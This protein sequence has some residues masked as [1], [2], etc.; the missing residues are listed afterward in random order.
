MLRRSLRGVRFS[1]TWSRF[2]APQMVYIAGEDFCEMY[3]E[4]M[5]RYTMELVMKKWVEPSIDT[6][7]WEYY[8]L[9]CK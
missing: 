6:S 5:S 2:T 8:D 7:K 3:G 9:S 4:E 1:S